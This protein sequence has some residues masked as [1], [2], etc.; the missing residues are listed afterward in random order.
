[1]LAHP[2]PSVTISMRGRVGA[3]MLQASLE[4]VRRLGEMRVPDTSGLM[5]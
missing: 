1:M 4:D 5:S 2:L 3:S